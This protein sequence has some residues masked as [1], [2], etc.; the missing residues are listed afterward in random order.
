VLAIAILHTVFNASNNDGGAIDGLLDGR[1]QNVVAVIAMVLVT[2]AVAA[3]VGTRRRRTPS[4]PLLELGGC[5]DA[6]SRQ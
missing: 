4:R 5:F 1:D 6:R 2:A 3:A